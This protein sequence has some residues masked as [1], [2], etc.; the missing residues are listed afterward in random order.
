MVNISD[1]LQDQYIK[2]AAI[3][4]RVE[5]G[6]RRRAASMV[7]RLRKEVA[8][9]LANRSPVAVYGPAR[10][11]ETL[12]RLSQ[13]LRD[14]VY[15]MRGDINKDLARLAGIEASWTTGTIGSA[16]AVDL[17]TLTLTSAQL[18]TIMGNILIE[19]APSAE[20]WGR[21]ISFAGSLPKALSPSC[22]Q[23]SPAS[24]S[25]LCWARMD[26]SR[27]ARCRNTSAIYVSPSY[28]IKPPI[29]CS[30]GLAEFGHWA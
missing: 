2:R 19:G 20:W 15:T 26:S 10:Q 30:M 22:S 13:V 29:R 12:R 5:G 4:N 16:L 6:M 17:G 11:K 21:M 25:Q 18:N 28:S 24:V 23:K 9:D 8:M 27:S 3:L 7:K 14:G 1:N